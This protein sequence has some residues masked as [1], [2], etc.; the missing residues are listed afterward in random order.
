M[1]KIVF[2][3]ALLSVTSKLFA[4]DCSQYMF[5]KKNRIIES[6][7]YNEKGNVLRKSVSTFI[8]TTTT[9]GVT[10]ATVSS[11]SFDKSGKSSGKKYFL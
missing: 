4:Q 11:E 2:I 9:N 3:I 1:K 8:N 5:M 6:T 7:S 10:T